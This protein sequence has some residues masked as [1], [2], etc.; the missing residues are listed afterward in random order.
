MVYTV[1]P[2]RPLFLDES[3]FI[4]MQYLDEYPC[5]TSTGYLFTDC[6][7]LSFSNAPIAMGVQGGEEQ[8]A[9]LSAYTPGGVR[10]S[11]TLC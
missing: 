10:V 4:L 6:Q 5:V 9:N 3:G 1:Y 11:S 8:N 2:V 7:E